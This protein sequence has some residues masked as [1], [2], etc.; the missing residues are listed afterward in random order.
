[1]IACDTQ[2]NVEMSFG[3]RTWTVSPADFRLAAIDD[4]S[5]LGAFFVLDIGG[6]APAWI[7][8]DT[9]LVSP[10]LPLPTYICELTPR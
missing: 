8:G 2:V 5:C 6:S 1:M 4:Q 10:S 3:G 7:V 9:F